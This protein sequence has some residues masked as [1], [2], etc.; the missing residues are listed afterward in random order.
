VRAR[1]R[2]DSGPPR[3]RAPG[4]LATVKHRELRGRASQR[5]GGCRRSVGTY[6]ASSV[7]RRARGAQRGR[8]RAEGAGRRRQGG[9]GGRADGETRKCSLNATFSRVV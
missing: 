2:G 7:G 4:Y 6:G 9:G 1:L 3:Y 5:S 8:G